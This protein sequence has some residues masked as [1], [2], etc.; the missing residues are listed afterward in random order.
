MILDCKEWME[1]PKPFGDDQNIKSVVAGK[2]AL[3]LVTED[4]DRDR[5]FVMGKNTNGILVR[6]HDQFDGTAG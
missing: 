2:D 5:L 6:V 4:T 1:L 3:Y